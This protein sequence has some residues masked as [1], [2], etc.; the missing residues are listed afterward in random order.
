MTQR[1]PRWSLIFLPIF[2]VSLL[3]TA[4]FGWQLYRSSSPLPAGFLAADKGYGVTIDLTLY[5][6]EALAGTLAALQQSGLTWLRQ[7]VNWAGLEPAPG[8]FSWQS[9][10]RL[11]EQIGNFSGDLKLMVVLHTSPDWARP[12]NT[13]A[14][15]PPTEVSDFGN[16]VRAFAARYGQQ[17]DYYQIWHEPNLSANW[18]NTFVDPAT[19]AGL[20][21]EAA[22]NIRAVDGEAY[23]LTAALAPTLENGPLNLNELAYLEQLYQA[24]AEQWFDIIA[25]QPYGFDSEPADPARPGTLNFSRTELIRQIMLNHGDAQTP[26]WATAFGWNALPADWAGQPSP[27]TSDTPAVQARRT[28]A[29]IAKARRDW[30]WLGPMLALRWDS[31]GLAAGDPARGFALLETPPILQAI[32]TAATQQ[33]TATPG[34]YPADHPSG[35]YS[36]GWR[37]ALTQADIPRHEPRRLTIAFEGTGLDLTVNRGPYRGYL[38]VTVDGQPANALPHDGQGRSYVILYDPL[39]ASETVAIARRLPPG[40]HHAV[41]EAEGGWGQWAIG[42]WTVHNHPDT[43]PAQTGLA[44]AGVL[45]TLSGLSLLWQ[46]FRAPAEIIKPA[47]ARLEI[48]VALSVALLKEPGQITL[49]G[50]LA[51]GFYLAP[52]IIALAVLPVLSL[53]ILL[54]PDLG[55]ALVAFSLSFFQAPKHLPF[56]SFS[57]VE[58]ALALTVAGFMFRALLALGRAAFAPAEANCRPSIFNDHRPTIRLTSVDLAALAL[59]VLALLSTLAA[60]NFGVSMREWRVVVFEPVLFYF[61][62]RLGLDFGSSPPRQLPSRRWAWRL[63]DA[64][65]AGAALQAL[66]AL[67]LY[68]FTDQSITAEGVRRALGLAYGSPNNL[69]LFLDRA[70]PILL[71]VTVLPGLKYRRWLY[72]AGLAVVSLALYL[73]FSKG[74]LFIGLPACVAGM[75]ILYSRHRPSAARLAP[76]NRRRIMVA[77]VVGLAIIILAVI[78]LSQTARFRTTFDFSP[79]STGFFRLKLWQASLAMLRDHWPLGVGLDNFLYQ[80]RT[81]YILP[82]AWQEPNLS[83]PHNLI[84]DFGTRLGIGGLALLLWL[85]A[86]FWGNAWQLYQKQPSPLMLGLMGSMIVFL[87]HGLVDNSYFLVDLALAFFLTMG[88]VQGLTEDGG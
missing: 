8:Q 23:L 76:Q 4:Y 69:S 84:L 37:F 11:I 14:T 57:P 7:P 47:W 27:W 22:L 39:R 85:Q 79:G 44:I 61:L 75:A 33:A 70:W 12:A 71:A 52:G 31:A 58:L 43:G 56:G 13:P 9:F 62:V 34:R 19:Y 41:I 30:P 20:L 81:R 86:A 64:F 68:F 45:A 32:Q 87:S 36:P 18:G 72:G 67:Y 35:Q 83:H 40:L 77:T 48:L 42:G 63:V 24:R 59:V 49:I 54:R 17:I 80:Y 55:L 66:I 21:R 16:F 26:L 29:A 38:W 25:V 73:T 46:L 51:I 74:A 2:I 78:P 6:D 88:I 3:A 15:T 82:E 65:V 28:A 10:D 5:D 53:A 60:E 1:P 50:V